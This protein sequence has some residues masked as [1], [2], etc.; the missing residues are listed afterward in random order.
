VNT[1][2][3]NVVNP[4][5]YLDGQVDGFISAR[6][7]AAY[8]LDDSHVLH[9]ER[10]TPGGGRISWHY[11]LECR[12]VVIFDASDFATPDYTTYGDAARGLMGF[13]TLMPGDTDDEYFD[14][15]TADQLTWR[16]EHAE[17][18]ALFGMEADR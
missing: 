18:M 14:S 15:Y 6:L 3:L 10:V 9:V 16:D 2:D 17:E 7:M 1:T 5:V 4:L 12:G 13:L 11:V 8:R